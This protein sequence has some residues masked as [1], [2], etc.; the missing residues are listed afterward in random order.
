MKTIS[1]IAVNHN[2]DRSTAYRTDDV[3]HAGDTAKINVLL[4]FFEIALSGYFFRD[5][6]M[7]LHANPKPILA[8]PELDAIHL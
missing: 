8:P 2:S 6:T 3:N 7:L 4:A 1:F 5:L